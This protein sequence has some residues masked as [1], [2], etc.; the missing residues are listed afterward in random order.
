MSSG[1]IEYATSTSDIPERYRDYVD[2]TLNTVADMSNLPANA[3][4]FGY[5]Q[6]GQ[7]WRPQYDAQGNITNASNLVTGGQA[8]VA[9]FSGDQQAA[10]Q[11]TRNQMGRYDPQLQAMSDIYGQIGL[12][13]NQITGQS[14][15]DYM[16]NYMNPYENQVVGQTINDMGRA[17][18]IAAENA[19]LGSAGR[20]AFGS[21]NDLAQTELQRNFLDRTGAMAGQLRQQGFNTA[22][23]LGMSDAERFQGAQAQNLAN[24]MAAA[25]GLGAGAQLGQSIAYQNINALGAQGANQQALNQAMRDVDYGEFM[26]Q[27]NYPIQAANMRLAALGMAPMGSVSTV[28]VQQQSGLGS[29][30]GGIGGLLGGVAGFF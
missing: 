23:Q 10:F 8:R 5:T 28:P 29:A 3:F 4:Q 2:Q 18:A 6:D 27:A 13:Q 9:G 1:G 11:A 15:A 26:Q 16:S 25:Q 20:G 17:Q 19:R 21:Q 24:R 12:G 7:A 14:G 22:A 30:L